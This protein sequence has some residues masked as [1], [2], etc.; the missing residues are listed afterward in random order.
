MQEI[1]DLCAEWKP[2]P[3]APEL[4]PAQKIETER[5]IA[6]MAG[7]TVEIDG[8]SV[9]SFANSDFVGLSTL[10]HGKEVCETTIHK[11][12]VGS[13]GPRGFYGTIDVHLELESE[14]ASFMG[15]EEAILYSYDIATFPS[16]IPAFANAKDLIICD[17]VR[18]S[19]FFM[20]GGVICSWR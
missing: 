20:Y 8:K 15:T 13:C 16:I 14:I 4:K 19:L 1:D 11:Y 18:D 10:Q 2:E 12:G 6:A 3:L 9:V 7:A 17:E 5:V